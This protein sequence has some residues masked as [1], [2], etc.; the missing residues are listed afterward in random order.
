MA[1]PTSLAWFARHEL[2]LAWRDWLSMM[3]AGKSGGADP[4]SGHVGFGICGSLD[5]RLDHQFLGAQCA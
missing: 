1:R 5:C 2:G 4:G 3:T